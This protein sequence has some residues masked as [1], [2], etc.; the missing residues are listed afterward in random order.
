MEIV[1]IDGENLHDL[2][3]FKEI[4]KKDVTYDNIKSHEKPVLHP[5]SR[6]YI[7]AKT[8]GEEGQIAPPLPPSPLQPFLKKI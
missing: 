8:A 7:L 1:Y 6:R 4:F 3:N 5:L 2:S